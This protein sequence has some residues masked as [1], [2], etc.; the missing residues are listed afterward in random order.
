MIYNRTNF[1]DTSQIL[2]NYVIY[3][4]NAA[5]PLILQSKFSQKIIEKRLSSKRSLVY[6]KPINNWL[7]SF[8]TIINKSIEDLFGDFLTKWEEP[9]SQLKVFLEDEVNSSLERPTIHSVFTASL[10]MFYV[11]QCQPN[12]HP[13]LAL[14]GDGGIYV[15]WQLNDKFISIQIDRETSEKDR[16]Y[17][18][19]GDQYGSTKLTK[20]SLKG[21]FG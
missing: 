6:H 2:N 13:E 17:I 20:D 11:Y 8:D 3:Q 21:I 1:V 10:Y 9:L 5:S 16:V 18:E 7:N 4:E 15:E 14:S 12:L 19:E